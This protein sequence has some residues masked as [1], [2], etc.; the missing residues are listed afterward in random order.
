[1]TKNYNF[2]SKDQNLIRFHVPM[3][4]SNRNY[5]NKM[6]ISPHEIFHGMPANDQKLNSLTSQQIKF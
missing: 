4:S 5:I 6:M 3:T 1:M 2:A